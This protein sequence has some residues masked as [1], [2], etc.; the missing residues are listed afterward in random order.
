VQQ[1]SA[2]QIGVDAGDVDP[3]G[4]QQQ[5]PLQSVHVATCGSAWHTALHDEASPPLVD[6]AASVAPP[7]PS[8]GPAA[9][10]S[11]LDEPPVP[12]VLLL[13]AASPTVDDAPMATM[14]WKSFSMFMKH[15]VPLMDELGTDRDV[16]RL[17]LERIVCGTRGFL[18]CSNTDPSRGS[19][20]TPFDCKG[21]P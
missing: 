19:G 16:S 5:Q 7:D 18:A 4:N 20:V 12:L 1:G 21:T 9:P 3:A 14:T 8:V 13:Q 11:S 2:P 15:T 17:A 6:I 10:L